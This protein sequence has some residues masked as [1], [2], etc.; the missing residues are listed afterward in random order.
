MSNTQSNTVKKTYHEE[1]KISRG[2]DGCQGIA[3]KEVSYYQRIG[4]IVELLK[5]VAEK[6]RYGKG[7]DLFPYTSLCH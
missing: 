7:Y 2:T 4:C 3:A 1:D 5:K 6:Q